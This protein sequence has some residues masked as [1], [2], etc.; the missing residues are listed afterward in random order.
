MIH[1]FFPLSLNTEVWE[2]GALGRESQTSMIVL[3]WNPMK[4]YFVGKDETG[5]NKHLAF[6]PHLKERQTG[7]EVKE[8]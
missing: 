2:V 1:D 8:K 6:V 3:M 7:K 4:N 5:T